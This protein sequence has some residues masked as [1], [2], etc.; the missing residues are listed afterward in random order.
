MFTG[1]RSSI[2]KTE[3]GTTYTLVDSDAEKFIIFNNAAAT[4]INLSPD[5]T[6]KFPAGTEIFITKHGNGNPTITR[7]AGVALLQTT[8]GGTDANYTLTNKYMLIRL[9]KL[10]ADTWQINNQN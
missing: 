2:V 1:I 7:G 4:T 6:T 5:S 3:T 8:G 9:K 10:S